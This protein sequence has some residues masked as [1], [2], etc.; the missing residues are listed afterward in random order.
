VVRAA[1]AY[2]HDIVAADGAEE[3]EV[4]KYGCLPD[5]IGTEDAILCRNTA[6]LIK[7]AYRL[8]RQGRAAKVEGRAIGERL[9]ALMER[10]KVTDT[11]TLLIRLDKYKAREIKNA[12]E[13]DNYSKVEQVSDRVET[14]C[15]I[16]AV[17]NDSGSNHVDDVISFIRNLFQDNA[18][19]A[20]ILSTYH[21]SKG[22]EWNRVL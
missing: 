4:V 8:I 9:M 16:I 20:I 18:P 17:V 15:H 6:P 10:W 22:K 12:K 19:N 3:G 14:L 13:R 2:V 1:Q 21:R 11:E 7:I 5:D